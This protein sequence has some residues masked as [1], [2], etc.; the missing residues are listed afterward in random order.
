MKTGRTDHHN[1]AYNTL[2]TQWVLHWHLFI[3]EFHPTF[4]YIKGVDN[5]VADAL[6]HLHIEALSE[7]GMI[8]HDVDPDYNA[9]AFSIEQDN[10]P[11]LEC[12]LHHPH[13]PGEIVY[14]LDY[15]LLHSQ[16]LQDV[17]LLQQQQNN[18]DKYPT[19]NLDGTKL[20]CY[21]AT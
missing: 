12:F 11:L 21:V 3:A 16:Q 5:V 2:S 14:P 17:L 1:L 18:P 13:L 9:E 7:V 20:N 4:H 15:P 19:I 10:E 8:Q 6:S